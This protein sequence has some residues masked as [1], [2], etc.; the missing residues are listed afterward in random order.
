MHVRRQ[1]LR[2][3]RRRRTPRSRTSSCSGPTAC[4]STTSAP[5][6]TTS[7]WASRSS[8]AGA[9]TWSTRRRRSCSTRRSARPVP[10]FAH[11]PMMLAPNGEKLSKRHGAVSVERVPRPG[12]LAARG[13]QLPRALRLVARRPGGVLA[14]RAR[15]RRSTGSTADESDGKF[16]A[17]KFLAIDHE[18]L[19]TPR[20]TG[21]DEYAQRTAPVPREARASTSR[22]ARV[23]RRRPADPRARDARSSRRPTPRLLLPR[24]ARDRRGRGREVPR[25]GE[26][27]APARPRRRAREGRAVDRA[28]ARRGGQR[29]ARRAPACRSRT[30]RSRRA[31]RS[32]AARRA[33]VSSSH[34]R[35]RAE[36][37]ARAA[38]G[39]GRCSDARVARRGLS[40][41]PWACD[42]RATGC[43]TCAVGWGLDRF[44]PGDQGPCTARCP[45]RPQGSKKSSH[46][47][48]AGDSIGSSSGTTTTTGAD[49][50]RGRRPR[51]TL[52]PK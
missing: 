26:R 17:K 42:D 13:A 37:R 36:R 7:R 6:S 35:P 1:G 30:W 44:A 11:L 39:G 21:D 24:A 23:E 27:A 43:R 28:G 2:R 38:T 9:T 33:R 16:D 51:R 5:S 8:R 3:G 40:R 52:K 47:N 29:V 14:G 41:R 31:S 19:K 48:S 4:R 45:R 46:E 12:V 32:P 34:R 10:E 15:R 20:L 25:P 49:R 22:A 50:A 18:H